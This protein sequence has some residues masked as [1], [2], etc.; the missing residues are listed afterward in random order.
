V[1][2]LMIHGFGSMI[3]EYA[4][5]GIEMADTW[6]IFGDPSVT[7]YTQMPT[8]MVVTHPASTILGS[9]QLTVNCDVEG[10]M[11]G[12]Y[13]HEELLA[14][15]LVEGGAVNF[16]F[17]PLSYPEPILVTV[18]AFNRMPY[19]G[20]IDVIAASGPFIVLDQYEIDD[21][22]GDMDAKADYGED[23]LLNVN[24]ANVGVETAANVNAVLSTADPLV[25]ITDNTATFG[26]ILADEFATEDGA[27]AFSVDLFAPDGHSV[28]FD[29]ELESD[30]VTWNSTINVLLHAP[31]LEVAEVA[32]LTD[33]VNGNG[34]NRMDPGEIVTIHITNFNE[35]H[36]DLPAGLGNLSTVSPYVTILNPQGA[37]AGIDEEGQGIISF[38]LEIN[39]DVPQIQPVEFNYAV[40]ADIFTGSATYDF[41]MNP[42]VEDFE[43]NDFETYEW[44]SAG[45][46]P[47]F[48]TTASPYEG[49]YCSQS[50]DIGNNSTSELILWSNVLEAGTISFARKVSSESGWDYLRFYIND[51]EQD[52]WS[53]EEDWTEVSYSV[54]E[55][56]NV[57]RWAYEKDQIVSDGADAG[58]VDGIYLPLI[59]EAV[60]ISSTTSEVAATELLVTPNPVQTTAHLQLELTEGGD[61]QVSICNLQGQVVKMAFDGRLIAGTHQFQVP[62]SELAAGTYLVIVQSGEDRLVRKL[63]RQ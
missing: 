39:M 49:A 35:G 1:G 57:F 58:W 11:I 44:Q 5:G 41:I 48:T 8:G 42:I 4:G 6:N 9:T 47:W 26:E 28:T 22:A 19:Q 23:I 7:L 17:D 38:D 56:D 33:A 3:D 24:L 51:V 40:E 62:V 12:L 37:L 14:T 63:V 10:A 52:E 36:D 31:I 50:G 29:V 54:Q 20:E 43:T 13:Y 59:E 2:G 55:G 45:I 32:T 18:T 34:N 53:G 27:F 30:G 46:V 25:T 60:I 21:S 61:V 16:D 15:G